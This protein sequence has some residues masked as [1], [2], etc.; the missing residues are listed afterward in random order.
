MV[1]LAIRARNLKDANLR[2]IKMA[3][4]GSDEGSTVFDRC[5]ELL[6]QMDTSAAM[7]VVSKLGQ[8]LEDKKSK[9]LTGKIKNE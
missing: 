7:V 9:E 8:Y 3:Q 5:R 2:R 1:W 4:P 6:D